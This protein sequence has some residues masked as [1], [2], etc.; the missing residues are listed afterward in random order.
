[1]INLI[2]NLLRF[3]RNQQLMSNAN[4]IDDIIYTCKHVLNDETHFLNV[5]IQ[6]IFERLATQSIKP[7]SLREYL[8]SGTVF[9]PI[10]TNP[11]KNIL[12][13]LNRVKCIISMT[14]PRDSRQHIGTS[15]VEFNMFVEGFGCLFLPSIAPQLTNAPSI[16]AMGMVSVGNDLS[17]NGGVG[18][19]ERV[20]PPQSG[21][22][23]S[24]WI[25]VDKFGK[26]SSLL[27]NNKIHPIRILTLLK[28]SKVKDTLSSCL[29]IYLSP[30]YRSLFVSTEET[31][32]QQQKMI[33]SNEDEDIKLS[34]N[35]VKFNCSELFQEGQWLH[36]TFVFSR[37]V[38]K[39]SSV[40]LYVNSNLIGTQK[41]NYIN[42]YLNSNSSPSAMGI[43]AVIGTLPQFRVQ[44]PVIWRQASCYLFEDIIQ[45][46]IIQSLYK[47]GPNY[48]GSFQSP[49]FETNSYDNTSNLLTSISSLVS[50]E[51]IVFGLHS[52]NIFEMTLSKF[53][54]IYNKNDSKAIGKLLNLPSNECVTPL[55][56]ISNTAAQLNGPARSVGGV[57]I[58]YLGVRTFQP[59]PVS[60]SIEH[61]GGVQ[62]LL[63]LIAMSNDI[64]FMYA[65]VKAL[66]CICKSNIEIAREMDRL[67][68][69]QLL[70]MLYKRK[71]SLI[72][73][74]ILNLSFSLVISDDTGKE[75]AIISNVKA[76]EYLLC[77]LEIWYETPIEIQRSLHE[78][79]NDLLNDVTNARLFHRLNMLKRF[80]FMIKEA[81]SNTLNDN[82][83]K[84]IISTIKILIV[85]TSQSEDLIKFGQYLASL[86]PDINTNEK[87]VNL[88][89]GNS[90]SSESLSSP[91]NSASTFTLTSSNNTDISLIYTIKLRNKLLSIID[92]I[93]SKQSCTKTITFQEEF[94]RLLGY[95]W[96]LLFMQPNVHKTTLIKS[97]RILFIL[98][99]NA[100]NLYKFK[101]SSF[102]GG[103]L[104]NIFSQL[105]PNTASTTPN[106]TPTTPTSSSSITT[107]TNPIKNTLMNSSVTSINSDSTT[108]STTQ[109]IQAQ[110]SFS[111][112]INLDACQV[113][114][115]QLM[116][117]YFSKNPDIVELYYLLFALL[118]D[119]QRIKELPEN[120]DLNLNSICKYVFDKSFDSEHNLFSK[121]N[122]DVSLDITIILLSMIRSLMNPSIK[123]DSDSKDYAIILL[124]I[125]RFMYHNC[126]DFRSMAS[127]LDFLSSLILTLYPYN[128]MT[129]Q[130][131]NEPSPAEIKPFAEAICNQDLDENS[132]YHSY[133]S[134]HPARKLVMD[135]LRDL[136]Y[137]GLI[138]SSNNINNSI[139]SYANYYYGTKQGQQVIDQ[140]LI[141]LP[142][143]SANLKRNQEF[144]TELFKTILDYLLSSDIFNEQPHLP[145]LNTNINFVLQNFFNLLDRL[146]DKLWDDMYRREPKEVF[147]LIIKFMNNLKKKPYNFSNEQLINSMNRCLLYQL[148]RPCE[149]LNEQI[150]MLDVLHKMSQLK[151][152]IFSP[153]NSQSDFFGC[154]A[155]CLLMITS[156]DDMGHMDLISPNTAEDI[157][158]KFQ[159]KTLWYANPNFNEKL[160]QSNNLSFD[161]I[162]SVNN[163]EN[164]N[165][166]AAKYLLVSAAQ[167]VW[168]ELYLNKKSNLEECLKVSLNSIGKN[169]T[170]DELRPI[171]TEPARKV[172]TSFIDGEKKLPERI[173]SHIQAKF[174]RVTDGIT[175]ITGG[176]SRVVSLKKQKKEAARLTQ[177]ELN[178]SINSILANMMSMKD[179][180]DSEYR[181][182]FRSNEQRHSYLY[183]EWLSIEKD[184]LRER[185]LWG[186]DV[187]DKLS[188]WKL[189][190]TEGPN[191]QRKR[192]LPNTAE[193]YKHY[194]YKPTIDFLKPNKKYKI[195]TSFDSKEYYNSFKV[196][197]L[198]HHQQNLLDKIATDREHQQMILQHQIEQQQQ[199]QDDFDPPSEIIYE[200]SQTNNEEVTN[201]NDEAS[202]P[203]IISNNPTYTTQSSS[204]TSYNQNITRLLEEGEKINHIYRCA[205]V[206]GL[207]T[208]EGVFLFGKE[209]FYVLD[210]FT[211]ISTKDIVD[212]DC[213]KPSAYEPLIP[214]SGGSTTKN[215]LTEKQCSKFA[216][217]DIRE[218]HNRRYLLQEI[219]MEIFSNDGRNY[220]LVFPRKCRNKIYERLIALT[221]DLNDSAQQSIAGQRRS[222]NIEQNTSI[223]NALIGEKSVV[224]RWERGEI[225][226]FQYLMFLNTLAGRSYNDLMQYPVF[227]WILAD[228][229]SDELDLNNSG[230][231]RDL[232]KPMGAQTQERLKQFEKRFVE[233]E[234]PTSETP[235]YFYGTHYSSAMIVASYLLRLEP[236]TQIFLRLQGGHFDLAD[237]LFH[238]VKDNWLSA[239]R[240]NMA[241]VKELIPEFFYLPEF[242]ANSN[243]F[244]LGRKQSGVVLN[245]VVLPPWA[246]N[247]PREF[248]R[249]HRM[250]LE[251]DYVSAHLNEWIDLIFGF[252]QQGQP[253][254][255][256]FNVFHHLFYEGA[257]NIDEIDD[258]LKRSAIIGFINNFG[259]IPKQLFK[260]PHPTK[261]LN[262]QFLYGIANNLVN[263]TLGSTA[264]NLVT[265]QS[266]NNQ[267]LTSN[268]SSSSLSFQ[269][270][271]QQL[272]FIH[273]LKSLKPSLQ[274]V[275]EL[276]SQVGQIVAIDK[277][278][279]SS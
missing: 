110:S 178:E 114:G 257:V 3:E 277:G 155:H 166:K 175:T 214:K 254:V 153:N 204:S 132:T 51:K 266:D 68:G 108:T 113:P 70:G 247:D 183:A 137:D 246:K 215:K 171:L 81:N 225:T 121:I 185:A 276:K 180:N 205:R 241:D 201:N 87:Y 193:F 154:L 223:L 190:L 264:V 13:P 239:S 52:Q 168:L 100:Q 256:S 73:S 173:Q 18:S 217:E 207:D 197:S 22:T 36:L 139:Q 109:S 179:Y 76:F 250:A 35:L 261:K 151:T 43:H 182:F 40:S 237:R 269:T 140:I 273:Y 65:S 78:R 199:Q 263:T 232:S 186:M 130:E 138:N 174:Q 66:V 97:C 64:E 164:N 5:S 131:L 272:V 111:V 29:S 189:D 133:L 105:K 134:I 63:G 128:D 19:G 244:D 59:M 126:D 71:K 21:I 53:R 102:C 191:R 79:F 187:E 211:L 106:A 188:K 112:D 12:I 236:F 216:Y 159:S 220:L 120:A 11:D 245:D 31:L 41:L 46:N 17:V 89:C 156:T 252:K 221:P 93:M 86:L 253:A 227:P 125:F 196:Q 267:Q 198:L 212:I 122:K 107:P 72:N 228:Y 162:T 145:Q 50:D 67:N 90:C 274:P 170:L 77:D 235:P 218:V 158:K 118:F 240:N 157:N 91:P 56:I 62:F 95:D 27:D 80:L 25:C 268:P 1:M 230:I 74:H 39:N 83:L 15:F 167:R 23:F 26:S 226:N 262:T 161:S 222:I 127:N 203:T 208:T 248:I 192:L 123:M 271:S 181:K 148:S 14:T 258:P 20:F 260:K 160:Q 234:D 103:W 233:W 124:Q 231:F 88:E 6:H 54:R 177:K 206:Q 149:S 150:G 279:Y 141:S 238:S 129:Q 255:D 24:T 104:N 7:K 94:Q 224:Q 249:V 278:Y 117:I 184:L 142:D 57:I 219:A 38:L 33:D 16:V 32:L 60:K 49:N 98:L 144:I 200:T 99:L 229:D 165:D 30:K 119:A 45:P 28:H 115:F 213:L 210:G 202:S 243:K 152:L 75:Q 242:L 136:L 195:P 116:Q 96:F 84:Y 4:F 251:S 176:F 37:A 61:I 42:S 85:E 8:R 47:L 169:P 265:A 58:G 146:V 163:N 44:S 101:D 82:T 2:K 69:Y 48:L 194:Q 10:S 55:R 135:F 209:H 143:N 92:D 34:D 270:T 259:Q 275:K 147:E 172:F 9:D